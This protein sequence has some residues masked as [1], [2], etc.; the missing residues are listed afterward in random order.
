MPAW[1]SEVRVPGQQTG[2][3]DIPYWRARCKP[4]RESSHLPF[5]RRYSL[6]GADTAKLTEMSDASETAFNFTNGPSA[7]GPVVFRLK[8]E[9]NFYSYAFPD[10][11]AGLTATAGVVGTIAESCDPS[12][13]NFAEPIDFQFLSSP[14]GRL[15]GTRARAVARD[16]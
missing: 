5:S 2:R 8:A 11:R 12:N 10:D 14:S 3:D 15:H 9:P 6:V 16:I 4:I 13:P 1:A 7:P